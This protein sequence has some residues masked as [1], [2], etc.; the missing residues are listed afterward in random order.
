MLAKKRTL[1]KLHT[2][3]EVR[4][5]NIMTQRTEQSELTK[6]DNEHPGKTFRCDVLATTSSRLKRR[7]IEMF[8]VSSS[9]PELQGQA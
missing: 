6:N 5:S 2:T 8:Y 9:G 7:F 1:V 4:V 3:F